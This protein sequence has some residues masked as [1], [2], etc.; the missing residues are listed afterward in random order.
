MSQKLLKELMAIAIIGVTM[1]A[2]FPL[3]N[4]RLKTDFDRYGAGAIALIVGCVLSD[5]AA[6]RVF[7]DET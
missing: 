2:I 5:F 4:P 6:K 3:I 7:K 1:T